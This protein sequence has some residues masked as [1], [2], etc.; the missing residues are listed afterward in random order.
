M[1]DLVISKSNI[2]WADP[3]R[4]RQREPSPLADCL[5]IEGRVLVLVSFPRRPFWRLACSCCPCPKG[6]VWSSTEPW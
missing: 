6:N 4:G 3:R 2:R 1:S 5:E